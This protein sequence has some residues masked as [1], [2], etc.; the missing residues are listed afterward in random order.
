MIVELRH[1]R[2]S[3]PSMYGHMLALPLF[4][5]KKLARGFER[6]GWRLGS[7]RAQWLLNQIDQTIYN[8]HAGTGVS[9]CGD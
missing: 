1:I 8:E 3:A 7:P 5:E 4:R 6:L 9:L 2:M